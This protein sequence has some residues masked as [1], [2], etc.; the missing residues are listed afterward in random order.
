MSGG[1]VADGLLWGTVRDRAK[2]KRGLERVREGE[3]IPPSA[4]LCTAGM[5]GRLFSH[6]TRL[7][8]AHIAV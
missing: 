1:N 4:T 3:G 2:T 6:V 7:A 5:P 8:K